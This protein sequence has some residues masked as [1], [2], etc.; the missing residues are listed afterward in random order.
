MSS[1]PWS[2]GQVD[3]FATCVLAANPGPMTLD[4]T[5]TWVLA[6]PDAD[7][8]LVV[9]PGPALAE[10]AA[11]VSRAIDRRRVAAVLLTHHHA[12]HSESAADLAASW[13]SPLIVSPADEAAGAGAEAGLSLRTLVTPGHTSDS[14]CLLLE[15][16]GLLLTG[17]SVLG[18]G[19]SVIAHP[20]GRLGDYLA[21]LDLL[22]AVVAE[23]DVRLLLPGHG[24]P[25]TQPA[26][27]LDFYRTHRQDRLAAVRGALAA[28]HGSLQAVVEDVYADV[29]PAMWPVAAL[30]VRAQLDYLAELGNL[31]AAQA[32]GVD[33]VTGPGWEP[34]GET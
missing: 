32:R 27:V 1:Q 14:I 8:C 17:D 31:A 34:D 2:G 28:G 4:G 21:S 11:A 20:D 30:S 33:E 26:P 3:P 6:A 5:N 15:G 19:T 25:I 29:D 7:A 10:H 16:P 12:D 9:D 24:P 23:R 22:A 18:R 13:E